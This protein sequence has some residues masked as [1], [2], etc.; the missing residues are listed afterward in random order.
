V[1]ESVQE[2][3]GAE[4]KSRYEE[5]AKVAKKAI[6]RAKKSVEKRIAYSKDDNNKQFN[7]YI[8]S[9]TKSRAPIG[10]IKREDGSL[11]IEEKD[12]AAELNKFFLASLRRRTGPTYH[13][14]KERLK[15]FWIRW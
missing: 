10:P 1:L 6:V 4:N 12:M 13:T 15:Q 3:G 11:A 14:N 7:S 2:R 9:K 8:K 5:A